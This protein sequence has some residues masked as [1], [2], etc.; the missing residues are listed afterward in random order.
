[1]KIKS[2][3]LAGLV[4]A[5]FFS[6]LFFVSPAQTIAGAKLVPVEGASYNVNASMKDNLKPFMGKKVYIHLTSGLTLS[7]IVKEIGEHI[8]HLEKLD[9]KDFFDA[10]ILIDSIAAIDAQFRE[11]EK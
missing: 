1:M 9:K 5:M 10:L 6:A 7:G 4:F 3:W 11:Y 2:L 8:I